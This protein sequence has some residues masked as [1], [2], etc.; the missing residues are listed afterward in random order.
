MID[1]PVT[2]KLALTPE[3]AAALTHLGEDNIRALCRA[4]AAFPAFMNG[5]NSLIPRKA[6]EEWLN[7]QGA[8]KLGFPE[9]I[10]TKGRRRT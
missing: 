1:I 7:D 5:R 2:E 8:L 3:E 10:R 4:N 9:W 6:L